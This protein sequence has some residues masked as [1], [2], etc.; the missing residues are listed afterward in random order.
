MTCTSVFTKAL[1]IISPKVE[2][3]S[4]FIHGQ[5]SNVYNIC[6]KKSCSDL[7]MEEL[8]IYG[9]DV[10]CNTDVFEDYAKP[11]K[12]HTKDKVRIIPFVYGIQT[13]TNTKAIGHL[14]ID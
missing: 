11:K 6:K 12:P 2:T 3:A 14:F 1:V 10:C 5:I 9:S 8:L 4:M 13:F 7:K